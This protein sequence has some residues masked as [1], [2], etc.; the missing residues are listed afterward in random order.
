M[1]TL[2]GISSP[3]SRVRILDILPLVT[4]TTTITR[5]I[6]IGSSASR[7]RPRPPPLLDVVG[8]PLARLL[9][10]EH[11]RRDAQRRRRQLAAAQLGHG[12]LAAGADDEDL[13]LLPFPRLRR[14]GAD[15][16]GG[17]SR[18]RESTKMCSKNWPVWC[19]FCSLVVDVRIRTVL[20]QIKVSSCTSRRDRNAP[21]PL[22][23]D[24]VGHSSTVCDSWPRLR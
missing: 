14:H 9:V 24:V 20:S 23:P 12:G 18:K 11:A 13:L 1:R 2:N 15:W 6:A 21:S 16:R 8:P 7:Y 10:L 4:T 19:R 22:R 5:P 3:L 17:C